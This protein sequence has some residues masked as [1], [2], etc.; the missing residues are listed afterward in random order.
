MKGFG[1]DDI[2]LGF[3]SKLDRIMGPSISTSWCKR[4]LSTYKM[5]AARALLRQLELGVEIDIAIWAGVNAKP[6]S[7]AFL[8]INDHQPIG[9]GVY[10]RHRT[11]FYTRSIDTMPA[12]DKHMGD[13]NMRHVSSLSFIHF[14]PKMSP[15]RLGLGIRGPIIAAVLVL[16]SNLALATSTALINIYYKSLHLCCPPS[17]QALSNK[18]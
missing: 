18:P 12:R 2:K 5:N 8:G 17:T 9:P 16:A 7:G 6:A 15:F 3:F 14:T 13:L 10:G 11:F 1:S 4:N